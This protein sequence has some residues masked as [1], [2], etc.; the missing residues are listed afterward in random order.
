MTAKKQTS[1]RLDH[2]G[3]TMPTMSAESIAATQHVMDLMQPSVLSPHQ[4]FLRLDLTDPLQ[5]RF[6]MDRFG[7]NESHP[8]GSF[9][10]R[11]E[12]ATH[13][14]R[15]H[16]AT[17]PLKRPVLHGMNAAPANGC[18]VPVAL[19]T[20]FNYDTT[21]PADSEV[22][23][24]G[25]ISIPGGFKLADASMEI[26]DSALAGQPIAT[27]ASSAYG[28]YDT[29]ANATGT[30]E[31][32]GDQATAL[33]SGHYTDSSHT[34]VPFVVSQMI[35]PQPS[36]TIQVRSPRH[37]VTTQGNP[38]SVALGRLPTGQADADYYFDPGNPGFKELLLSVS[39]SATT[40]SSSFVF[41]PG[42]NV[43]GSLVLLKRDGAAP[44]GATVVYPNDV[45]SACQID[46]QV[47]NWNFNSGPFNA[48]DFGVPVPWSYGDVILMA[49]NLTAKVNGPSGQS[50]CNL[51]VTSDQSGAS[52][53]QIG[54]T[55]FIDMLQFFWGCLAAHARV[56][57]ADGGEKAIRDVQIGECV[58]GPEGAIWWVSNIKTGTEKKPMF[59][60]ETE[61]G[62]TV[63]VT[64]G[65]PILTASGPRVARVLSLGDRI[66]TQR[67]D[68]TIVQINQVSYDGA[69]FNL[70][71]ANEDGSSADAAAFYA[72]GIL[73]GDNQMQTVAERS[74]VAESA[75]EVL[76]ALS[77]SNGDWLHYL[78]EQRRIHEALS[79][80]HTLDVG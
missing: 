58:A 71:L 57:M 42:Q 63:L 68:A 43:T 9:P 72:D 13:L 78:E 27:G 28:Q 23:A 5:H 50:S 3:R 38:I 29:V 26:F 6:F 37:K 1:P 59:E 4:K 7:K 35:G 32:S 70:V 73:V 39:G 16:V 15:P 41:S 47:L 18:Y 20:A 76:E 11:A 36:L 61:Y 17:A 14:A 31:S 56:R 25:I 53:Q 34:T 45:A 67:G 2:W 21:G 30:L 77:R 48:A 65:H 69:I 51:A 55:F 52:G 49:L 79:S 60:I 33:F 80:A 22:I 44:G 75:W 62:D 19:I 12:L 46:G 40:Q 64:D 8:L 10:S 54:N 74:A 66:V 24:E